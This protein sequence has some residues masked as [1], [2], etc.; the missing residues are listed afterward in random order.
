MLRLD[1]NLLFTAANLL[2]WFFLI[3]K[4]LFKPINN[5]ISKR[6]EAIASQYA[7]AQKLQEAA[8]A[9]KEKCT[10]FQGQIEQEKAAAVTEAQKKARTEYDR[11]V[12]EAKDKA[13]QIVEASRKEAELEKARIVGKAEQEIR[14]VIMDAAVKSMQSSGGDQGL[15]DQFLTKAGE[16]HAE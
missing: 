8:A 12:T 7:K 1:I 15:Y 11:I 10:K 9:E 14:S 16:T 13:E 3:R 5:V 4:F 2:I 6:E